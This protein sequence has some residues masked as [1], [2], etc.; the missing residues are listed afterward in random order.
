MFHPD[1]DRLFFIG[2]F[3]PQGCIWPL[4]DLQ[5]KLAANHIMGRWQRP[6]NIAKLAEQDADYIAKEFLHSK[7]HTIEVHYHP[8]QKA[9]LKQI[10]A[11]APEWKV[12]EEV[13]ID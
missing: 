4:A 1:Q 9:L 5:A 11:N 8:F 13:L 3:Q 6:Q 7:R 10:P 12:Q 2:L